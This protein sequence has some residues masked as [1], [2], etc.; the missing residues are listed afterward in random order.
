MFLP[1]ALAATA[2]AAIRPEDSPPL[3]A[4]SL[5]AL[6][7]G[8][9]WAGRRCGMRGARWLLLLCSLGVLLWPEIA[10]RAAGLRF[11]T[12]HKAFRLK[13]G[14]RI[15]Y[16]LGFHSGSGIEDAGIECLNMRNVRFVRTYFSAD[17]TRML[18]LY[19]APDAEMVR[20]AQ[21]EAGVPFDD[22]WSFVIVDPNHHIAT[23]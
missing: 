22:A 6:W 18:C 15:Q 1:P 5:T 2:V 7:F 8:T 12:A 17:R 20:Q 23:D 16:D 11:D 21:R 14:G 19:D 13:L 4:L 3:L 10:L 9:F